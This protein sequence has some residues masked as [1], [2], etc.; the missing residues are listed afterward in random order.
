VSESYR[1]RRGPLAIAVGLVA[2]M[3]VTSLAVWNASE[4][5]FAGYTDNTGNRWQTGTVVLTD[6]D[7]GSTAMFND[8]ATLYTPNSASVVKCITV[9]YGGSSTLTNPVKLYGLASSV[10]SSTLAPYID[11]KIESGA[12]SANAGPPNFTCGTF[13]GATTIWA[14]GT[15][16]RLSDFES[17]MVSYGCGLSTGWTPTA[18]GQTKSFRFTTTIVDNNAAQGLSLTGIPFTWEAQG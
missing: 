17:T 11:L 16:Q 12:D 3:L 9:T 14:G 8:S 10:S 7:G 2:G 5:A 15:G 6:N 1:R 4:S 13:T 18:S